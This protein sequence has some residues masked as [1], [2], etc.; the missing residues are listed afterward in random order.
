MTAL[1]EKLQAARDILAPWAGEFQTPEPNRVDVPIAAENL[2]AAVEA[3]NAA[4]WGYLAA[5]TGLDMG[6]EAGQIEVLY[7][8]CEGAAVLTLR[9]ATPRA[10]AT[11]PSVCPVIPSASIFERELIEMMGITVTGTPDRGRLFLADDWPD[12]VYPLRKDAVLEL[13]AKEQSNE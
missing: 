11:V 13:G 7:H 8:F 4:R 10:E 1:E 6:A 3:L 9:V 2:L 12:G 5:I